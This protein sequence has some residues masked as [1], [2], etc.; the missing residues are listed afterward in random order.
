M[1][2]TAQLQTAGSTRCAH[3]PTA[4]SRRLLSSTALLTPFV[5][6]ETALADT[7]SLDALKQLSY[8]Q[9]VAPKASIVAADAARKAADLNLNGIEDATPLVAGLAVGILLVGGAIAFIANGSKGPAIK[10]RTTKC[11]SQLVTS[12]A[13]RLRKV[14]IDLD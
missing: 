9:T 3:V 7:P 6:V 5:L 13:L 8:D 10:V 12:H 4:F 2:R 1:S 11:N 14:W